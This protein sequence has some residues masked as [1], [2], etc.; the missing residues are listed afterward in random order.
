MKNRIAGILML[1]CLVAPMVATYTW[2]QCKK[3]LAHEE[4]KRQ[5]AAGIGREELFLLKFAREE[6]QTRLHWK[7]AREFEYRGQMYDIAETETKGDT[8]YYW[9]WWDHEETKLNRRLDGVLAY[10]LGKKFPNRDTQK[11]LVHFFRSLYCP[12]VPSW[13]TS[14]GHRTRRAA[15]AYFFILPAIYFSPP[16]PPPERTG[17]V[18]S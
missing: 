14:A 4:V 9:C 17:F 6:T 13:T 1:F 5:M 7:N 12:N 3:M 10:A 15:F 2:L 18:F 8:I 16:A 11:R